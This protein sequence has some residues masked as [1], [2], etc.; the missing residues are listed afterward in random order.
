MT[1]TDTDRAIGAAADF[2]DIVVAIAQ[3]PNLATDLAVLALETVCRGVMTGEG[4]PP[5]AACISPAPSMAPMRPCA[6]RS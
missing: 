6:R 3:A 2:N 4:R 1:A 5:V